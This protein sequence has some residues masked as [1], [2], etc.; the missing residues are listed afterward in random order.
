MQYE[1]FYL[2]ARSREA[3]LP[4]IRESVTKIVTEEGGVFE[5]KETVEKRKLSYQIKHETHGAYI[6]Q[7]FELEDTEKLRTITRKLNLSPDILRFLISRASE[8][9]ELKSREERIEAGE[10]LAK[11]KERSAEIKKTTEEEKKAEPA[12][13]KKPAPQEEDIDK[14]LEEILNI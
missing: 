12:K 9:P 8:L 13:E 14:K 10:R 7:R 11:E 2:V 1:L 5:P 3:D 4:K 6:A